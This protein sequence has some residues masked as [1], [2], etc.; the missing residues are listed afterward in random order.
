MM[1][2]GLLYFLR[3]NAMTTSKYN[4]LAP[5]DKCMV[6]ATISEENN[7]SKQYAMG[8]DDPKLTDLRKELLSSVERIKQMEGY[9]HDGK[10]PWAKCLPKP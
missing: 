5:Q 8:V 4:S 2:C 10:A 9:A 6:D 3:G 7:L 1:V